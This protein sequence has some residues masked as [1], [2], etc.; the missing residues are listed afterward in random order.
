[1]SIQE[2]PGQGWFDQVH[3]GG[4]W[5]DKKCF[6]KH[7]QPRANQSRLQS[8]E[9]PEGDSNGKQLRDN[10]IGAIGYPG[11]CFETHLAGTW[12]DV[13]KRLRSYTFITP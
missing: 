4:G 10:E 11:V 3:Q 9:S 8:L 6:I 2:R 5:K 12:E 7:Y 1:M 13:G